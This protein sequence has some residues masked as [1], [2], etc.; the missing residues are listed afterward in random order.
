MYTITF[1]IPVRYGQTITCASESMPQGELAD[2]IRTLTEAGYTILAVDVE[3]PEWYDMDGEELLVD[4][5][6]ELE[7]DEYLYITEE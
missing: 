2:F 3:H 4:V 6:E 7:E 1:S 5:L